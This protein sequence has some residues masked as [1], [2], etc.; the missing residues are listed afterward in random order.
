MSKH[1]FYLFSTADAE[2]LT[3]TSL[4]IARS[5]QAL[6]YKTG[7][8][9]PIS[10]AN[11]QHQ[12]SGLSRHLAR[13]HLD[14][15]APESISLDHALE[16]LSNDKMN[17]LIDEVLT[18]VNEAGEGKDLM[19]VEGLFPSP[20][21]SG[22]DRINFEVAN[23]LNAE[24]IIISN[25]NKGMNEAINRIRV[26]Q[27]GL[28]GMPGTRIKG[29]ILNQVEKETWYKMRHGSGYRK[30]RG[31]PLRLPI[32]AAIPDNP[33]LVAPRVY[34]IATLLNA[35]VIYKG[36]YK[37]RRVHN[38]EICARTAANAIDSIHPGT[39]VIT[40][41]DRQDI[42]L[43]TLMMAL[44]G[45]S[46]AGLLLTSN[47]LPDPRLNRLMEQVKITGLPI[48]SCDMSTWEATSTLMNRSKQL[49]EDDPEQVELVLDYFASNIDL[50]YLQK[51]IDVIPVNRLTP[52]AFR[53]QLVGLAR[54]ANKRIVLPE[55][56]EPRTIKAAIICHKRKIARCVLL[57]R[58]AEI[59]RIA[60][61]EE[62][63]LPDNLEII[64]P[65]SIAP[66]Y[67]EP[68][69]KLRE[70]KGMNAPLAAKN[71]EDPIYV[72]TM[73]LALDEVDGL[74]AGAI[75]TTA[76]T[77]RPAFQLIKTRPDAKVV[78]SIFFMLLPKEVVI[79]GD[80]AVNPDPNA[81]QLADIAVQSLQS[82]KAFGIDPRVAMI[83]YSTGSSGSGADVEK[84]RAAT[85]LAQQ[86]LPGELI[87][88]PLQYD[89]ASVESVGKQ[90]APDS[91]VAGNATV[92]I[93][94]D[95]NTGNTTYKAVQRSAG[96]VSVGP[97]LQGLNK[98]VNDL[99]R[100]ALV[101]DIV[102]TIALTAIQA[103]QPKA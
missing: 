24:T 88:G 49:I 22:Q 30:T 5:F 10:Q 11:Q 91:P 37:T 74:V 43:L 40:S 84:V 64:D 53:F 89:A 56:E 96:V 75:N 55:G 68:L 35:E 25:A 3:S 16:L 9:K 70:H 44:S 48:L 58:R 95:L 54:K 28:Q 47:L 90:K 34:D 71:L 94:P 66:N 77:I 17:D 29:C 18:R 62:L 83:S 98:P 36:H 61:N 99:S 102:Y 82:A 26:A 101:E 7:F 81:D 97:M 92:F 8:C 67:V 41:G 85:E 6:G 12:V 79:Y 21:R 93:F 14:L 23:A 1:T 42:L 50:P 52:P 27:N 39:L 60:N 2:G 78:S 19:V 103:T 73:M 87:D 65:E 76:A 13:D 69:I 72:G 46:I 15:H 51:A 100:G 31:M 80:C 4:A 63:S 45:T 38:I 86:T 32:I 20:G 33:S 59:E 57:G